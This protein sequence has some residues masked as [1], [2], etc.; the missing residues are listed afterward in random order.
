M[1]SEGHF[2]AGA[3]PGFYERRWLT[4]QPKGHVIIIHG[5]REHCAR[6]D[7]VAQELN[8]RGLSAYSF[9]QRGHGRSPGKKG[10]INRFDDFLNDFDHYLKHV[11]PD[12]G[13]APVGVLAH[14]MGTLVFARYVQTRD[15][16]PKA[17]AISSPFFEIP[18]VSPALL[19][20]AGVLS[21]WTPWLPVA[22][23]ES[24][25]ISRVPEV[26][27]AY[28]AD[29]LNGHG[30]I[31]ARTGAELTNAV[32][33]ARA[34]MERIR[35]PL[36]VMHGTADRLAPFSGGRYYYEH[37]ASADKTWR[38]FDGG[39]HELMNDTVQEEARR[40]VAD[41]LEQRLCA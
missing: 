28:D 26:V 14:S 34:Q 19:A 2:D 8:A 37:A 21:A 30:P 9:D 32:R 17:A 41:W 7:H 6:Y 3:L 24:A 33:I 36:F 20:V 16:A 11:R 23:L 1:I 5:F 31:A 38:E 12:F 27:T 40:E 18:P 29:P 15:W 39:Y 22:N 4:P 13:G 25:A 10:Y 35:M